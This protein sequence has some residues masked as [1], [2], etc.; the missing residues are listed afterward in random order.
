MTDLNCCL[1]SSSNI[2]IPYLIQQSFE[3]PQAQLEANR[4]IVV[5]RDEKHPAHPGDPAFR[6]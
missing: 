1:I 5:Q 6:R 3:F 4:S 2:R